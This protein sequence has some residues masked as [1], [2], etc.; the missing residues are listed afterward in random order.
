MDLRQSVI[1]Y[2]RSLKKCTCKLCLKAI[3]PP[4]FI[5]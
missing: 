5:C 1:L 3:T 2:E 4:L